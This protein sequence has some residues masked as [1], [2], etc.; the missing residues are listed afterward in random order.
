MR[1][2][3]EPFKN[4]LIDKRDTKRLENDGQ[5]EQEKIYQSSADGE[6]FQEG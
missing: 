1:P 3:D 2:I 6:T 5:T 4:I